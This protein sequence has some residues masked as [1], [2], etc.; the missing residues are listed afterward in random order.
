MTLA[1]TDADDL[2]WAVDIRHLE[3]SELGN[4]QAGGIDGHQNG[5]VFEVAGGFE[6]CRH[7]RGT[8]YYRQFLLVPRVRNM[9]NHPV[10]VQGVMIEKT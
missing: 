5:A 9:F 7:F 4:A 8:Q 10:A 3:V 2:S 1:L 6:D